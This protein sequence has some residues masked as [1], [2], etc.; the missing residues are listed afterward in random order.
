MPQGA[1]TKAQSTNGTQP[2]QRCWKFSQNYEPKPSFRKPPNF[3][4]LGWK[5]LHN[6]KRIIKES[7][8]NSYLEDDLQKKLEIDGVLKKNKFWVEWWFERGLAREMRVFE[9][10]S[11]LLHKNWKHV[12]F[13]S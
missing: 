5:I 2:N 10:L 13:A 9:N 12:F 1:N 11:H 3:K 6:L 8:R 4:A 7:F